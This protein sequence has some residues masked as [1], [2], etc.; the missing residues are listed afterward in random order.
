MRKPAP[1]EVVIVSYNANDMQSYQKA[2]SESAKSV[3]VGGC[4]DLMHIG[5]IRFLKQAKKAGDLLVV[6]LESDEFIQAS[7]H[8]E[9]V[10][11]QAMRAEQLAS[12]RY[13]DVIV[14]LPYLTSHQDYDA[15]VAALAP[16]VIAT[17]AGDSGQIYKIRQAHALG[18]ELM[19]VTPLI[20][21]YSSSSIIHELLSRD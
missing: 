3:L 9:P 2:V 14:L 8:R 15:M 5:H 16:D 7:K 1:S 13:V 21:D 20:T 4:F 11:S 19:E 17:T 6:V 12:N 18:I 10:H